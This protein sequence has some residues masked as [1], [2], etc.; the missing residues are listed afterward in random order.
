MYNLVNEFLKSINHKK[1]KKCFEKFWKENDFMSM[2]T[3][4][5]LIQ[6]MKS[7]RKCLTKEMY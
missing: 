6:F 5:E 4:K 1:Y 3:K 7:L 2:N